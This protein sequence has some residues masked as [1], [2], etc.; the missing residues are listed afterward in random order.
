MLDSLID[1][2]SARPLLSES[3]LYAEYFQG[4]RQR[5][6][7]V[8]MCTGCEIVQWPP[9]EICGVCQNSRFVPADVPTEGETYTYSVM[10]RAF[11]PAFKDAVPYGVVVVEPAPGVRI[12]GRYVGPDPDSLECGQRMT[13]VFDDLGIDSG[14][15]AWRRIDE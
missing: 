12:I 14:S 8:R 5:R 10:Y 2:E 13:A 7:I 6:I 3:P 4:L 11:H 1:A 9:R 15:I